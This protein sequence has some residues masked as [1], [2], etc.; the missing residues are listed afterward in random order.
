MLFIVFFNEYSIW[1]IMLCFKIEF[2]KSGFLLKVVMLLD[3]DYIF[4]DCVVVVV[5]F[6]CVKMLWGKELVGIYFLC[7]KINV[8]EVEEMVD[9]IVSV[10]GEVFDDYNEEI[11]KVFEVM[12]MI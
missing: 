5:N 2:N 1:E 12:R 10:F 9:Y 7:K 11:E 8:Q 6:F 3:M 4:I